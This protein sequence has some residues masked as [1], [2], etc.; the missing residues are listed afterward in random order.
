MNP[1]NVLYDFHS[2]NTIVG[3]RACV[4]RNSMYFITKETKEL[5]ENMLLYEQAKKALCK[6]LNSIQ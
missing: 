2:K 3:I 4:F 6:N 5:L 1:Q